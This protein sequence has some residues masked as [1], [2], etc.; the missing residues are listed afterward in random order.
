MRSSKD[1]DAPGTTEEGGVGDENSRLWYQSLLLWLNL[2]NLLSNPLNTSFVSL[3]D[4]FQTLFL[5]G[6][7]VPDSFYQVLV[8]SFG[9][10]DESTS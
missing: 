4:I 7:C 2:F 8:S 3:G 1:T 10:E 6:V 5:P 9:L